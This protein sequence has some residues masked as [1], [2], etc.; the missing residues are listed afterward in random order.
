MP[1][2]RENMPDWVNYVAQDADGQWWGYETEPNL[3]HISW[4]ENEVGRIVK[5][6]KTKAQS[7]WQQ[8][9]L[10]VTD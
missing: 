9:L 4:Y 2:K 6:D 10:K 3:S 5:L 1:L 8:S 7:H